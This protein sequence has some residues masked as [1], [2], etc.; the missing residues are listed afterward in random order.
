MILAEEFI[1]LF[2]GYMEAQ[3]SQVC[4]NVFG[5][6]VYLDVSR[7]TTCGGTTI[8]GVSLE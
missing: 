4:S 6:G 2:P 5:G 3:Q 8:T 1:L 7:S